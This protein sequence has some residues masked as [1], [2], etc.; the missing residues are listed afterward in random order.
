MPQR[1]VIDSLSFVRDEGS[2]QGELPVSGLAR[3]H[4]WLSATDGA[5]RYR[6]DAARGP[7]GEPQL[8]IEIDALLQVRCQRCLESMRYPLELRNLLELVSREVDLSQEE[9]EDDSKDL[10]PAQRELDVVALIEDEI[11]LALPL[12]PRH[13]SCT[14]PALGQGANS[15]SPFAAL[16]A[17]KGRSS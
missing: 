5:V 10:L 2:L 15:V 8:R 3:L 9:V 14:P 6:V 4:D 17:L 13:E 1:I 11:I 16:T 12:A 7:Q